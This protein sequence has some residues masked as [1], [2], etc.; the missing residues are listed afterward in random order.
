MLLQ[1][2]PADMRHCTQAAD[3]LYKFKKNG[4]L[5]SAVAIHDNMTETEVA[6]W[7]KS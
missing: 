5:R 6:K 2:L 7:K 3:S 4:T 1:G